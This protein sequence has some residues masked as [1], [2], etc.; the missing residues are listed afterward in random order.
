MLLVLFS[1]LALY[2]VPVILVLVGAF[3]GEIGNE[4]GQLF[5]VA[6]ALSTDFV[7]FIRDV[8]A[9]FVIPLFAIFSVP[10]RETDDI[11]KSTMTLFFV[12]VGFLAATGGAYAWTVAQ[13]ATIRGSEVNPEI[14]QR[15]LK[16]YGREYFIYIALTFG[17]SVK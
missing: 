1:T 11:P 6:V 16:T 10:L 14:L 4:P 2:S 9:A 17:V 15:A 3:W 7:G 8:F 13:E 5:R 12:L